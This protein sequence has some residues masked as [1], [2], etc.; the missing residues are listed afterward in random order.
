VVANEYDYFTAIDDH[1]DDDEEEDA[2]AG[3]IGTVEF[4]S[5]TLYRYADVDVDRLRDNLGDGD[6]T[7]RAVEAF[8]RSFVLSMP[9]GKQNTFA[10]RTLPDAV[11]VVVRETQ[12]V[13]LVGAFEVAV[14][15]TSGRLAEA[16][17]MLGK[18]AVEQHAAF[19]ETP[20]ASWCVGGSDAVEPL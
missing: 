5:S 4:N 10:N 18:H 12:P 6:V 1:K 13:N 8:V 3:M 19:D 9:S 16:V 17:R 20:V 14:D 7:R 2:G 11:F 15:Q